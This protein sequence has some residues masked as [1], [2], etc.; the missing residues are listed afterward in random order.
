[1]IRK[2]LLEKTPFDERLLNY[3]HEDTLMGYALKKRNVE[4]I[5]IQNPTLNGDIEDN[6]LFLQKTEEGIE[7]LIKILN[8]EKVDQDFIEDVSLLQFFCK[9]KGV[10]KIIAFG[11]FLFKPLIRAI[12]T[13]GFAS[14]LL[15]DLYKIG[16]F[17]NSL[18]LLDNQQFCQ[19]NKP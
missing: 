2:E 12:L 4:I 11:F 14:L 10:V 18:H 9:F 1:M 7:S 3:G 17:N 5:H 6:D 16:H 8:L 13:N 19:K 15:F